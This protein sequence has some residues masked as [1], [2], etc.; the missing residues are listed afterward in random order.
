MRASDLALDELLD[1]HRDGGILR[2]AGQ[3]AMLLDTV[4]L[5]LL[6]KELV[7]VFGLEVA[8]GILTR[9]GYAHGWRTAET[10]ERALPWTSADEWRQAGGRLHRLQGLVSFEPVH[11][12]E[13]A[14]PPAFA[15][16]I[17][18]ESYEA[19]QHLLHFGEADAPVCWS[20]AGFAS[21]YLSRA[22]GRPVYCI[23][24]HCRGRGDPLCRMRGDGREYFIEHGLEHELR[25]YDQCDLDESLSRVRGTL[26]KLERRLRSRRRVLDEEPSAGE[27][28]PDGLIA[29]SSAMRELLD[30]ARRVA[31]VDSTVLI[32]GP[33]GSGKERLAR[34]IHEHSARSGGP[35]IAV[36]CGAMPE[37]LLES[38]LF[39]HA[40]GSFSGATRDRAGLFEAAHTG[41]LLL[42]EVGEL[43]PAT[44]TRLLR[45]LQEREVRRLGENF[46]R[47]VD[48]R[49]LAAT[50]RDLA[51]EV[52]AGRFREDLLYRLR[53]VELVV[54]GLRDRPEDVLPLARALLASASLRLGRQLD[55]F[56]P[57]ACEALL[58]HDWPG[59]VRELQNAIERAVAL[60]RSSRIEAE[61]LPRLE[62]RARVDLGPGARM[63]EHAA[64]H[65]RLDL[66]LAE[67]ER[68]H[69]L[70]VLDASNGNK[71]EAARRLGI[72]TATLFRKIKRYKSP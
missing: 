50:H 71:A 13:R 68:E 2:F 64:E 30:L 63:R 54:P 14:E 29:R 52:D 58:A 3:R 6:R 15:E 18:R 59:N 67:I 24:T 69:I 28:E 38:E 57:T 7:D 51:A 47:A 1:F 22:H 36:N 8:R 39:G 43:S 35:L 40:K 34:F 53:V 60:A 12:S 72:G 9:F 42:D 66:P 56:A 33:T 41:T 32:G 62:P 27:P 5:G 46:S 45:V 17:W 11:S 16:A 48:V 65:R 25:Y 19:D 37:P 49:I 23:E 26:R 21:G 20:L 55:G 31:P 4:A 44:Q 10:L 61:D 70:A